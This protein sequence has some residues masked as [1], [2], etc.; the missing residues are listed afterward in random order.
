MKKL[1]FALLH[2]AGVTRLA[3]WRNRRRV[4]FLCYHGV[5]ERTTRAAHDPHGIHVPAPLFERQLDYL[6]SRYRVIPL[7]EY[8]AARREGRRLPPYCAVLTFDDGFRNFLTAAAPRLAARRLPA[9]LFVIT[10]KTADE[11]DAGN[12]SAAHDALRWS[13]ADDLTHL[14]WSEL[15]ALAREHGFEIGSHTCSHSRLPSLT[16]AETERELRDSFAAVALLAGEG[17]PA[18]SYPKGDYSSV[19]ARLARSVGYACAVTVDGGANDPAHTDPFALGRHLIGDRD[20]RAAFAVRVSGVRDSLARLRAACRR[21]FPAA[22]RQPRAEVR[23][24]AGGTTE[25]Y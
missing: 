15:R 8:L 14:S 9:S 11:D 3:A 4:V 25:H 1:L 6:V 12:D 23:L 20:D 17:A 10:D 19:L 18:L 22:A 7:S 5:T 13:P 24:R 21:L 16:P 2:A